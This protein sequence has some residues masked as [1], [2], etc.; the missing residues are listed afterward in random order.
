MAPPPLFWFISAKFW[1]HSSISEVQHERQPNPEIR[2]GND[3]YV[4]ESETKII[5][6]P[7]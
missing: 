2:T 6:L 5:C 7:K 3:V 4:G 1:S